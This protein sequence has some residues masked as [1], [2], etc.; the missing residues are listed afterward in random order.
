VQVFLFGLYPAR[1]VLVQTRRHSA[2]REYFAYAGEV[3]GHRGQPAWIS[4]LATAW[5]SHPDGIQR[6]GDEDVV[7]AECLMGVGRVL[8]SAF[9][10]VDGGPVLEWE[11]EV[12]RC[13]FK[14]CRQERGGVP[15]DVG[16]PVDECVDGGE[17]EVGQDLQELGEGRELPRVKVAVGQ[18]GP[19]QRVDREFHGTRSS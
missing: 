1:H 4:R 12:S 3:G 7:E 9:G 14:A 19:L 17:A 5:T 6:V 10:L 2:V 11:G 15:V 8:S 18:R 16:W 13:C